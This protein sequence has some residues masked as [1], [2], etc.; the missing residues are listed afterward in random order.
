MKLGM[1]SPEIQRGTVDALF[2]AASGYGFECIQFDFTSLPPADD[3]TDLYSR[4]L[5]GDHMPETLSNTALQE[6]KSAA[7]KYGVSLTAVNGTYNMAHR[8]ASERAIGISRLETVAKACKY[9]E[10]P[11]ITLCTGSRL[12][13]GWAYGWEWDDANTEPAA[14][15][16]MRDSMEKACRV[17]EKYDIRLGIEIE[18]SNVVDTAEKAARLFEEVGSQRLGLIYDAAN[19]FKTGDVVHTQAIETMKRTFDLLQDR[20]VLVHGK[21][22]ANKPGLHFTSCGKGIVDFDYCLGRVKQIGYSGPM[23]I[24]GV[25]SEQLFPDSVEYMKGAIAKAEL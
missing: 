17:A 7:E 15:E 22:L 21:D 14:W 9:L 5:R 20:I 11:M 8:A 3:E 24:H 2:K 18:A 19:L 4:T 13:K 6:V 10:S 1:Y 12:D 25:H 16:D 23:I